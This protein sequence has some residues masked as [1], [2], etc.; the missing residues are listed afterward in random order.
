[1]HNFF[2][3]MKDV[4]LVLCVAFGSLGTS[5]GNASGG[6]DAGGGGGTAGGYVSHGSLGSP[7]APAVTEA[8]TTRL[9]A[10]LIEVLYPATA[11]PEADVDGNGLPD[12]WE[13]EYFGS[14]GTNPSGDAD[15]DGTSEELEF[16]A[17]TN[18]RDPNSVFRPEILSNDGSPALSFPTVT[19]RDYRIW[20]SADLK[21]WTVLETRAGSGA[22][23]EIPV[24]PAA[25]ED[26]IFLRVEILLP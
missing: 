1:M 4:L 2:F 22:M 15:G 7:Y 5:A 10:G 24:I 25:G 8:G 3:M 21:E 12:E 23:V 9:R 26:R 14:T 13:W 11:N 19:E 6:L 16:F 20:Q 17:G 18:P